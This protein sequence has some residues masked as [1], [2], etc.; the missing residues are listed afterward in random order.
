MEV[1]NAKEDEIR[2]EF[3]S[4]TSGD[5]DRGTWTPRRA[6]RRWSDGVADETRTLRR[7]ARRPAG[8]TPDDERGD[9]DET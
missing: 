2:E 5:V 7:F 9:A 8:K 1:K 3:P 4:K 6:V